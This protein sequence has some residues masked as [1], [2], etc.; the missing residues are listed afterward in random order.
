[1]SDYALHPEALDDID[2]I[3]QY[4]ANDSVDASQGGRRDALARGWPGTGAP[5][6]EEKK[7]RGP[8]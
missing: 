7:Q 8:H 3:W 1:M 4:I 6:G 2:D 5:H